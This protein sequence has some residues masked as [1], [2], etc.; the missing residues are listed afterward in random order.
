MARRMKPARL[1]V[2]RPMCITMDHSTSDNSAR[3]KETGDEL[4]RACISF[5]FT[6]PVII[7]NYVWLTCMSQTEGPKPQIGCSVGDTAKAVLYGVDRLMHCHI[8]KDKLWDRNRTSKRYRIS[9]WTSRKQPLYDR[10][11]GPHRRSLVQCVWMIIQGINR[12]S[13]SP[14]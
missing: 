2:D 6:S 3:N 13:Y 5:Q 12:K 10:S 4:K 8:C 14:L 9:A 7:I 11:G 1:R